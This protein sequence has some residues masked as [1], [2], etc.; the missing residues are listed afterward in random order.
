MASI[1]ITLARTSKSVRYRVRLHFADFESRRAGERVF[2]V[3]IQDDEV[4]TGFDVVKA[5]G[6]PRRSTVREVTG[7]AVGKHL[8]VEFKAITGVPLLCGAE[9]RIQDE[10]VGRRP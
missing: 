9:I 10:Q 1:R 2:N 5:A 6:G 4:L 3:S 7:V 8:N